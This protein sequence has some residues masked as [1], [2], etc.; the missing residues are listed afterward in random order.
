MEFLYIDKPNDID[1]NL[2]REIS[3]RSDLCVSLRKFEDT[4]DLSF[5][6][7]MDNNEIVHCGLKYFSSNVCDRLLLATMSWTFLRPES[8]VASTSWLASFHVLIIRRGVLEK[9]DLDLGYRNA[10][11]LAADLAFQVLKGGGTVLYEPRLI[12]ASPT[13][14]DIASVPPDDLKR[15]VLRF[16]GKRPCLVAFPLSFLETWLRHSPRKLPPFSGIF[17]LTLPA[18]RVQIK[19]YTAVIPTINRYAFLKKAI[20]SLLN[21]RLRPAE[22]VVV[23]QTPEALR[24]PGYYDEFD[25][26]LVK[27][28]FMQK[29]GQSTARNEALSHAT[30]E[31]ILFF[32]DDS[33]AWDDMIQEHIWLLEHSKADVSTGV[34][35]APWKDRTYIADEINFYHIA[36]VLDT[37][38]C[39]MRRETVEKVGRF[40]YAFDKGSG[41]DDN[42]G[43]RLYLAGMR[44]VFNPKAIR[45]HHKAPVGGLREYGAWW[46]NKGT[47]F[48]PFPL[49]TQSYDFL[50]FYP[51]KYYVRL[52][53]YRLAT[54]FR[55]SN[56]LMN[57][58]NILLFPIKVLLSYRRAKTLMVVG[59]GR[60]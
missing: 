23:D 38:N 58:A 34:S 60:R 52:C 14:D 6:D 28:Y 53:L 44:I 26:A 13:A 2:V 50:S 32:D 18:R 30:K 29:A 56:W 24:I 45:T 47:L 12:P 16:F 49:P 43:K 42:L 11:F 35:L 31:W 4:I 21:N 10:H 25:P 1:W 20:Y 55:R 51:K 48:G 8:T 3:S 15:F 36:S 37:G 33:E 9:L 7:P 19:D 54:S 39:M 40:D 27:V 5:L 22:I 46:K 17:D 41:A 57:F 59:L